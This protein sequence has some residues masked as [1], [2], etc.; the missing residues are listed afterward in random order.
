MNSLFLIP[1]EAFFDALYDLGFRV[2]TSE[3]LS[4]AK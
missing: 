2:T 1:E 4:I 3:K